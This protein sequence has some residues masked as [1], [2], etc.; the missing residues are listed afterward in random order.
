M[1]KKL[2]LVGEV[3]LRENLDS[4][5]SSAALVV[6]VS[7]DLDREEP[8]GAGDETIFLDTSHGAACGETCNKRPA[9]AD[10]IQVRPTL[11]IQLTEHLLT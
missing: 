10:C 7:G 4:T 3:E 2:S 5:G 11:T 8:D 9:G 6:D 1:S